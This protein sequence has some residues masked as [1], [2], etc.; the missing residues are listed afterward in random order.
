M[1]YCLNCSAWRSVLD[2]REQVKKYDTEFS[3][4]HNAPRQARFFDANVAHA[5]QAL[6][7][8][9]CSAF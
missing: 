4:V 6:F 7:S 5:V 3:D 2:D 8:G 9:H 1:S